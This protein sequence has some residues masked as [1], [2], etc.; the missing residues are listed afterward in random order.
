MK[1]GVQFFTVQMALC[2][3]GHLA[4]SMDSCDLGSRRVLETD[5]PTCGQWLQL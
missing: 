3:V 4:F 5:H 2:V 1:E